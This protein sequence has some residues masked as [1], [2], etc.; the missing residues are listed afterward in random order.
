MRAQERRRR[1]ASRARR[2]RCATGPAA[3]AAAPARPLA[4]RRARPGRAADGRTR[5]RRRT[6]RRPCACRASRHHS[7]TVSPRTVTAG[8][9]PAGS[10]G[11][12]PAFDEQV[13]CPAI[14]AAASTRERSAERGGRD[15]S[16]TGFGLQTTD[17]RRRAAGAG[18]RG[19]VRTPRTRAADTGAAVKPPGQRAPS[20]LKDGS[21]TRSVQATVGV[22]G[23]TVKFWASTLR[24]PPCAPVVSCEPRL[25][26]RRRIMPTMQA[27]WP[28]AS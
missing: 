9:R 26:R 14:A 17:G 16:G 15:P 24:A 10:A 19:L 2:A 8:A 25:D 3:S 13:A 27:W 18:C 12:G 7:V 1:A 5:A 21:S 28:V 22:K 20:V 6:A 4:T 11:T 23:S